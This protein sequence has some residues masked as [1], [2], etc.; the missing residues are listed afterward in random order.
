MSLV[1]VTL[2]PAPPP[3]APA[4]ALEGPAT[5]RGGAAPA[6]P[7]LPVPRA[8]SPGAL[9]GALVKLSAS[10]PELTLLALEKESD[11]LGVAA[12]E[13]MIRSLG[14]F[15]AAEHAANQEHLRKAIAAASSKG[16]WQKFL[17]VL[18]GIAIAAS[19]A[20][21]GTVGAL[22]AGLMVAAW[23]VER[24]H[25]KVALGLQLAAVGLLV[26]NAVTSIAAP[27]ANTAAGAGATWR[28]GAKYVAGGAQVGCALGTAMVGHY[29][30]AELHAEAARLL[31]KQLLERSQQGQRDELSFMKALLE[32]DA[33]VTRN[34]ATMGES[35]HDATV[36]AI[37]V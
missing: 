10:T 4:P 3:L 19:L 36:A 14:S 15:I 20:T 9:V 2:R 23:A 22:A 24:S 17:A 34:C 37:R 31:A 16:W 35:R 30:A 28:A 7:H 5:R 11:R 6:P 26:G 27:G 29:Q 18:K 25:P 33:R 12:S 13:H 32:Q 1:A 21:S 8:V